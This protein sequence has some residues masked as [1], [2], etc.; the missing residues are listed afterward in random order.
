MKHE[1][2]SVALL[3]LSFKCPL[4][5]IV[6]LSGGIMKTIYVSDLLVQAVGIEVHLYGWLKNRRESGGI[7]FLDVCD[8]TG[9]IQSVCEERNLL[10]EIFGVIRRIP[11]ESAVE[12]KGVLCEHQNR[13]REIRVTEFLIVAE[14]SLKL[15]PQPRNH[16]NIFDEAMAD[17]LLRHRHIYLRNPQVMAIMRFRSSLMAFV[18]E[19]FQMNRF[20]ELDAPIL[21]PVPLYDD[22]T[23]LKLDVHGESVFL[24][25]CAG[26][27]LEAAA[28]AFE[29][30]YNMGPSFRG[31]ESRSRRHL[32]EYWHI[33]AEVAFAGLDDIIGCVEDIIQAV[34]RRCQ[35]E[36]ADIPHILGTSMCLDGLSPPFP[37]IRYEDAIKRLQ[38][39]GFDI[40]FGSGLG[41]VEEEELS[42]DFRTP[43]WITGI[44][45]S[46]E[47]F[48]YVVD[49]DDPRVTRVADLIASNGYGELLGVAEKISDPAM[50]DER[51]E[52]KGRLDDERYEWIREVHRSGCVPHAAFG[53]GLERL[54]R[55]LLNIPHVRDTI[56]FPRIF[57]RHIRP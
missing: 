44:P 40:S 14:D 31:E 45:R 23:A 39:R 48:P 16:V 43:F 19:W 10:S 1:S 29:R 54:I 55:W 35:Q 46:I 47:P 50:L 17:H 22:G 8:S 30:V 51:M 3:Q 41:S 56:P 25:Q 37:R 42:K 11:L 33:K 2:V 38:K 4:V 5:Q 18:R 36:L 13:P 52:E 32:M 27:Y 20:M 53:M 57:R 15:S 49:P 9:V 34:S 24:T 7:I 6:L 12:V 28:H 21:T 26:Y